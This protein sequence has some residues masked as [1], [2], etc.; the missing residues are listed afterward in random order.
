MADYELNN[1]EIVQMIKDVI[2]E[3]N[4]F[5]LKMID[6]PDIQV[7]RA[8]GKSSNSY[9]DVRKI[10]HPASLFTNKRWLITFYDIFEDLTPDKQKIVV[11]H[12]LLHID[13]EHD[14][15]K[16]HDVEDFKYIL[17]K[18]GVSWETK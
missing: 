14:K 15:L 13:I 1:P 12:E 6:V 16:K 5:D 11:L 10:G 4:K 18:Y 8:F 7:V 3:D 2:E 9:A 17:E